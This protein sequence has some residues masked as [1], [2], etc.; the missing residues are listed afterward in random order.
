M[1]ER[2]PRRTPLTITVDLLAVAIVAAGLGILA[3][4]LWHAVDSPALAIGALAMLSAGY[5]M[6]DLLTGFVHWFCDTFFD[7]TTP[8][9]GPA[10]I[11]PFR[12]HHRDPLLMTQHGFL[13][14]TGSSFRGLAPLLM[15]IVWMG[16]PLPVHVNA[17]V[18]ALATGA[19][20]TNLLHRWAHEPAPPAF[21]R[22]L[23][24]TGLVLTPVRHARHH[25]PPYAA[26]YC[27]TSGWLNPICER[28]QIWSRAEAV[29][30]AL[31]LPVSRADRE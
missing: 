17:F 15:L 20:C 29:F 18:F 3:Y 9:I 4:R 13:E 28:L 7:E 22:V 30:T 23:Q 6:A 16:Q 25:A 14:L 24:S 27:V 21:A 19:V 1:P 11:A 26:G 31:G 2:Q 8:L 12:E 5:V 10:L